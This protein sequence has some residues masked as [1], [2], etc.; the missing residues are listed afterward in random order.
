MNPQEI[1]DKL[2][3]EQEM[4]PDAHDGSYELMREI[5]NSYATV[6]DYSDIDYKDLNAVYAMAIGT[7][8][9]N[10]EIKKNYVKAGH[11]SSDEKERI[12][13]VIDKIWDNACYNRYENRNGNKP[14]IGM[15]GS[16]FFSYEGKA[17]NLSCQRLVLCQDNGQ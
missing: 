15:F 16:G 5:I 14:S 12:C 1:L 8:K 2:K 9:M 4:N 11:L 17:D 10:P 7:W 13:V 6:T 3:Q